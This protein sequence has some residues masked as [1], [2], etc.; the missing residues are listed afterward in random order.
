[1]GYSMN[2]ET[3]DHSTLSRLAEAGTLR[4]TH[5]TGQH[6]GWS[7]VV[8]YGMAERT[9]AAQRSQQ[10]RV[11]RKFETLV[12]YLKGLGIDR[13]DVDTVNYDPQSLTRTRNRPDRSAAMKAAHEAAAYDTWLK[14]EVQEAIDDSDPSIPHEEVMLNVRSVIAQARAA[15]RA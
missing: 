9:L 5:I 12:N 4:S 14:A 10:A 7:V 6:G 2:P 13:F 11:F 15:K 8:K 1:M 3:I